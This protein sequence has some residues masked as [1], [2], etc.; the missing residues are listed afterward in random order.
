[1]QEIGGGALIPALDA[2]FAH[3]LEMLPMFLPLAAFLATLMAFQKLTVSSEFAIIQSAG[4]SLARAMRPM[5]T[6]AAIVGI[7]AATVVNPLSVGYGAV[8]S[9][10]EKIDGA[11]WLHDSANGIT[12]RAL[13]ADGGSSGLTLI[14]ATII[15]QDSA[16]RIASRIDAKEVSVKDGKLSAQHA[17][18]FGSEGLERTM[19]WSVDS[20]LDPGAVLS[21][22][23]KPSQVSFWKLPKLIKSLSSIGIPT[24]AHELQFLSLLF[25]PLVL[26]A[27]TTLGAAFSHSRS[28]RRFSFARQFAAGIICCFCAYFAMQIFGAM[29]NSGALP[30]IVAAFMPPGIVL[31]AALA[32]INKNATV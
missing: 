28:P 31:F 5:T 4:L 29:G 22:S 24:T 30:P 11:V 10:L 14:D 18:I 32:A 16:F 7:I 3:F 1:M 9:R 6:T 27:M 23:L 12:V 2:S 20:N 15:I 21:R 19:N 25:L 26:A 17:K 8:A 13:D